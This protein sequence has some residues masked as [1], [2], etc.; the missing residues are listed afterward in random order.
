MC[1]CVCMCMY[2]CV[3]VCMCVCVYVFKCVC[4]YVCICVYVYIY[5]CENMY[6][7]IYWERLRRVTA[8][9]RLRRSVAHSA[10]WGVGCDID[11]KMK[12]ESIKMESIIYEKSFKNQWKWDPKSM[13]IEPWGRPG[14]LGSNLRCLRPI[15]AAIWWV[16]GRS[17]GHFGVQVGVRIGL[18]R[19][20]ERSETLLILSLIWRWIFEA[21]WSELGPILA[22]KTFPKW[23]QVGSKIDASWSVDLRAVFG[24]MLATFLSNFQHNMILPK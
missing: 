1:V 6:I 5:I 9:P 17:W 19:S 11:L 3:Y 22:P 7:C 4:V 23:G 2:V 18:N 8:A 10:K 24:R 15:L 20:Q 13:K 14:H 21:L 16:L 12:P